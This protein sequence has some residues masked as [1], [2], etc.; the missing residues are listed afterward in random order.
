MLCMLYVTS[1]RVVGADC[2]QRQTCSQ[3][4]ETLLPGVLGELGSTQE[5]RPVILKPLAATRSSQ[6]PAEQRRSCLETVREAIVEGSLSISPA[7]DSSA[8]R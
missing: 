8:R 7:R 3:Q 6:A 2:G 5:P 1:A 4:P